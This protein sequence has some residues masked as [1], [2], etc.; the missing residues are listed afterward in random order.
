MVRLLKLWW[1][2]FSSPQPLVSRTAAGRIYMWCE[3]AVKDCRASRYNKSHQL[4]F[5]SSLDL[6]QSSASIFPYSGL[7]VRTAPSL[8]VASHPAPPESPKRARPRGLFPPLLLTLLNTPTPSL[9]LVVIAPPPRRCTV[10]G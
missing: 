9:Q 5:K 1:R 2:K 3:P 8:V 10:G 6:L 7:R 4:Q